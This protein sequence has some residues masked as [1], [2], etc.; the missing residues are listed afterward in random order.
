MILSDVELISELGTGRL[1]IEP[2]PP[3]ENFSGASVDLRLASTLLVMPQT[4]GVTVDPAQI[5]DINE[6]LARSGDLKNLD[7]IESYDMAPG[8]FVI[9]STFETLTI[10]QHLMARVEGKSSL[11]RSGLAVHQTAPTIQ[12]GFEGSLT[13]EMYN[14]G[15][16]RVKLTPQMKVCQ[17]IVERM[18]LPAVRGSTSQFQDQT[19]V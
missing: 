4:A 10:P 5:E 8:E 9:A 12:P 16:F 7:Q 17:L 2:A 6:H 1:K 19:P 3:P 14:S 11:A 18:G 13:L 15:P